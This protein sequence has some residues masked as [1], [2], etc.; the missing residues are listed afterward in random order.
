MREI[1]EPDLASRTTIR[2]GGRAIAE[3]VLEN[4]ADARQL[5]ERVSELGAPA[6]IL[7]AGSNILAMDGQIPLALVR[8]G[9]K[10]KLE[11]WTIAGDK[12]LVKAGAGLPLRHLLRFCLKNGLS[13]LE[14]LIGIPGSVGGAVAMNAGSFGTQAGGAIHS[15]L[16]W[17]PE[18]VKL[19][20]REGINFEYR[21]ATFKNLPQM[22][23]ILEA[24]FTLT[25]TVKGV[26]SRRMHLNFIEKKS[27]QPLKAWS[28]GCVFKNPQQGLSAGRLLDQA[29][30]R[31]KS[32]GGMAFSAQ[33][34]NFLI[35]EGK[36]TSAAAMDLINMARERV[37]SLF[38]IKLEL[39]VRIIP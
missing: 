32:L 36:G 1:A 5:A 13:G 21:R 37:D 7:G 24:I 29:G 4:M 2:L 12:A 33:H 15:C 30:F 18:G 31:G 23:V 10:P 25:P 35:N 28:A 11:V 16:V 14:G 6:F 27:R 19:V 38:G 9:I 20:K 8:V 39:E 26:I 34:A 3:L 22:P 17:S